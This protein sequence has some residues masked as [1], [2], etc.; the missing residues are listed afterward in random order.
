MGLVSDRQPIRIVEARR[1]KVE[2]WNSSFM[3]RL[4]YLDSLVSLDL[5]ATV[6]LGD[7]ALATG[8]LVEKPDLTVT[9]RL[10]EPGLTSAG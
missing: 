7:A 10:R 5:C 8:P 1:T 4:L 3:G 9:E 6:M 2:P